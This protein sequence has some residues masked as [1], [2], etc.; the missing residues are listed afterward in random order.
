VM[1]G[2]GERAATAAEL[3][4]RAGHQDLSILA[5]GPHDWARATGRTLDAS[6]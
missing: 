1:C 2:H 3:L 4:E 5:G 6:P